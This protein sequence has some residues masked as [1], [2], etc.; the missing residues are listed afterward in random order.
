MYK[1]LFDVLPMTP[2]P[3][4]KAPVMRPFRPIL[5]LF[6]GR[7]ACHYELEDGSFHTGYYTEVSP[8]DDLSLP[9]NSE[10]VLDAI[11]EYS[12]RVVEYHKHVS[13]TISR[14][15]EEPMGFVQ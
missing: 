12:K 9:G 6:D 7:L 1:S 5:H 13:I 8:E 10:A 2:G 4:V 3:F 14:A 11:D 15:D